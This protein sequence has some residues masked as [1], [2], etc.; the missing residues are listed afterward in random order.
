MRSYNALRHASST[1][2]LIEGWEATKQPHLRQAIDRAIAYLVNNL[3]SV[4]TLADG[5]QAAFLCDVENEIKL[6]G[7]AVSILALVKY[8]ETTAIDNIWTCCRNWPP[9][10]HLCRTRKAVSLFMSLTATISH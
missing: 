2:S 4:R 10:L 5:R 9:E 6:G 8:T 1:Y 3:I 7:N